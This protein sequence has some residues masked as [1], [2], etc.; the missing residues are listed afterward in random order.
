MLSETVYATYPFNAVNDDEISFQRG[1]PI[2]VLEKDDIYADGWWLGQN[3]HGH[4]GL[5]PMNYTSYSRPASHSSSGGSVQNSVEKTATENNSN[6]GGR[7]TK[8]PS[9]LPSFNGRTKISGPEPRMQSPLVSYIQNKLHELVMDNEKTPDISNSPPTT[10]N[11]EQVCQWLRKEGLDSVID[12]FVE[13]DITGD[14]LIN[15]DRDSLKE[16]NIVSY[17]KRIRIMNA[18]KVLRS[19]HIPDANESYNN[20]STNDQR[21]NGNSGQNTRSPTLKSTTSGSTVGDLQPYTEQRV[22]SDTGKRLFSSMSTGTSQEVVKNTNSFGSPDGDKIQTMAEKYFG[23]K[24]QKILS[25]LSLASREDKEDERNNGTMVFSRGREVENE[26]YEKN[27]GEKISHHFSFKSKKKK[28]RSN[29]TTNGGWNFWMEGEEVETKEFDDGERF[30]SKTLGASYRPIFS[31]KDQSPESIFRGNL[32]K[33]LPM[34]QNGSQTGQPKYSVEEVRES[35]YP[36][37]RFTESDEEKVILKNIGTPDYEGWLKKQGDRYRSWKSRYCI[38]KGVNLY[39][40]QSEKQ[41]VQTPRVKGHLNL[42]GY[43]V[44]SDEGVLHGK[45]GF[46]LIHDTKRTYYFAHDNL[47]KTR[48]WMKAIMKATISRDIGSP[49]I[50]SSNLTT[51]SLSEAQNMNQK[52]LNSTKLGRP[53]SPMTPSPILQISAPIATRPTAYGRSDVF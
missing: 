7:S 28:K 34:D 45:Y 27:G 21:S 24:S 36:E 52:I 33:N 15:L 31:E 40:L 8:P 35:D 42:T 5:F 11:V 47:E 22:S 19:E 44:I 48:G 13:N 2:I 29:L 3:I 51:V 20:K 49:V 4:I 12:H 1:D 50:S 32:K 43:R 39:Y 6:N 16:L 25:K 30:K 26:I 37:S 14:I 18:I 41:S 9:P 46:K 23:K 38:L 53:K 10:W 17:G